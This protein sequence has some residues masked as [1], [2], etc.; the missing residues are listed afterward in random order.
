MAHDNEYTISYGKLRIP[1]YRVFARPLSGVTP[2]P[3]S[4]FAGRSNALLALE[5]DV[6]VFGANF[7]PAYTEGDNAN[8]VATDSMK[9]WV[10]RQALVYDGATLEG[11]L[12][13]LGRGFL[14]AYPQMQS[15]RV[16]ARQ[17]PY[18]PVRVPQGGAGTLGEH[19]FGASAVLYAR[20]R[21]D[22]AT[23]TLEFARED[24]GGGAIL[25]AHRCGYTGMRLL[26]ITGSSFT[27]FVRDDYTT[28]PERGDRPLAIA[29]DIT[30]R[31]ADAG[32]MLSADH[33]RYV[34]AEQVRDLVQVVFHEFVSESIQHLVHEM[35]QRLLARFPPLAEV[36]FAAQN[37]TP[38]PMAVSEADPTIKVYSDAFPAYGLI[39]L[40]L[41][42][43]GNA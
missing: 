26:K 22:S 8:V 29:L 25:I 20:A 41:A 4:S 12:D 19:A 32:A 3:E 36:A 24:A 33:A 42:R 28:L 27:R 23:A 43:E 2:I 11:F 38:D 10:L 13:L 15:L 30:W 1:F 21:D 39:K 37:H 17:L 9:N 31:Y 14:A 40:T 35:G 18:D 5:V 34:P 7:L 16:T 6:E